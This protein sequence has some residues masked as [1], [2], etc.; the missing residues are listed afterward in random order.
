MATAA[1]PN[2]AAPNIAAPNIAAP[3]P[4]IELV[5]TPTFL[6]KKY[7]TYVKAR[8]RNAPNSSNDTKTT[9]MPRN[10]QDEHHALLPPPLTDG[11]DSPA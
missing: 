8:L 9:I 10:I 1:V 4:S 3:D 6:P 5:A 2:I 7:F 11:C